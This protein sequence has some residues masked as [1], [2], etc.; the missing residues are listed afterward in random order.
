MTNF[1]V[2]SCVKLTQKLCVNFVNIFSMCKSTTFLNVNSLTFKQ[3]FIRG[4]VPKLCTFTQA[5]L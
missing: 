1:C 2:K 4:G 5:L 3:R